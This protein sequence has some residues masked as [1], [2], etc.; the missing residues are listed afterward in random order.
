MRLYKMHTNTDK[1]DKKSK[2]Y[3]DIKDITDYS[4]L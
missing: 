2:K 4:L 1:Y 3:I